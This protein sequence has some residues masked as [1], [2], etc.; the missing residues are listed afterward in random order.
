MHYLVRIRLD[1]I[2]YYL[3]LRFATGSVQFK[4]YVTVTWFTDL[5]VFKTVFGFLWKQ[6]WHGSWNAFTVHK[7]SSKSI[8][9]HVN[10]WGFI[11]GGSLNYQDW[12][13]KSDLNS[14]TISCNGTQGFRCLHDWRYSRFPLL[15]PDLKLFLTLTLSDLPAPSRVTRNNQMRL[16][17]AGGAYTNGHGG[18]TTGRRGAENVPP[19]QQPPQQPP[20]NSRV[21]QQVT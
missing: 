9:W 5:N 6:R 8:K 19:P 18:D 10:K 2:L 21:T 1:R 14:T 15:S 3:L 16:S 12:F 11:C 4:Y 7:Y 17:N 13:S 20:P